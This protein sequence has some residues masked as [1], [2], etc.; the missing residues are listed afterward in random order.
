MGFKEKLIRFMQGRYGNDRLATGSVD[1]GAYVWK[2][3]PDE[4]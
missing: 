1:L 4:Q 3:I 2:Y